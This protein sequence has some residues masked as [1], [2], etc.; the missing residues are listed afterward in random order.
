[1]GVD[2]M[3]KIITRQ[4]WHDLFKHPRRGQQRERQRV[5][6][7][8]L[9][10]QWDCEQ[11]RNFFFFCGTDRRSSVWSHP[12]WSVLQQGVGDCYKVRCMDVCLSTK[13]PYFCVKRLF[14]FAV[15]GMILTDFLSFRCLNPNPEERPDIVEVRC[16][17]ESL[18]CQ[19]LHLRWSK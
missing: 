14:L 5:K 3:N 11:F 19:T 18:Q 10:K 13:V 7:V 9:T 4:P 16:C 17:A 1:M 12:F 15:L 2:F 8:R 6:G